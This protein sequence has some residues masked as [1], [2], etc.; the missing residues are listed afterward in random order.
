VWLYVIGG[1]F[2][3]V[4]LVFPRGIVGLFYRLR[5]RRPA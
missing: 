1:L 5:R 3:L 4:V 2:V